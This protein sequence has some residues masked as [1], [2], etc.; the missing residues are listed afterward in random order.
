V[1]SIREKSISPKSNSRNSSTT[2]AN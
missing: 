2:I 1:K